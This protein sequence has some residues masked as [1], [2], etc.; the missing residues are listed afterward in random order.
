MSVS[1]VSPSVWNSHA[2]W[3]RL[4]SARAK[5][6][7]DLMPCQ[8]PPAVITSDRAAIVAAESEVGRIE[9]AR[10]AAIARFESSGRFLDVTV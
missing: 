3:S 5:L 7:T 10:A 8:A 6:A 9:A 4:S 2:A 1:P